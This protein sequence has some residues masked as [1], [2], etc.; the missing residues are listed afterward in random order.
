MHAH[1]LALVGGSGEQPPR[2][3]MVAAHPVLILA[4]MYV[5]QAAEALRQPLAYGRRPFKASA[6]WVL[7]PRCLQHTV[8]GEETHDPVQVVGVEGSQE[9][10][11]DSS[12]VC[13]H[14]FIMPAH[15]PWEHRASG[16]AGGYI[17]RRRLTGPATATCPG[18]GGWASPRAGPRQRHSRERTFA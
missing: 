6:P 18:G 16:I 8:V 9:S 4:V 3:A 17:G 14:A 15:K 13:V 10:R 7:A 5:R 2:D 11:E 1:M 12:I